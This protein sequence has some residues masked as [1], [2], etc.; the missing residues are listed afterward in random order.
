VSGGLVCAEELLISAQ[1]RGPHIEELI[2]PEDLLIRGDDD[3][4]VRQTILS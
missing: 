3:L 1:D 2:S 4:D